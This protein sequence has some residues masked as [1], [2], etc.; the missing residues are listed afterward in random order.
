MAYRIKN[1]RQFQHYHDKNVPWIKMY[2]HAVRDF[3]FRSMTERVQLR[4]I[5]LWLAAPTFMVSDANGGGKEPLLPDKAPAMSLSASIDITKRDIKMMVDK[6]FLIAESRQPLDN[7]RQSLD[8][9]YREREGERYTEEREGR[10]RFAPPTL[11]EVDSYI[12]EQGYS[13]FDGARFVDYYQARGW[14]LKGGAPLK[15]WKAAVRTW[16]RRREVE[17]GVPAPNPEAEAE[18]QLAKKHGWVK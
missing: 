2:A 1:W 9:V 16:G 15:D 17:S 18:Y 12:R 13:G 14:K 6:G 5:F 7:S 10:Q 8:K 4:L 3:E 11:A